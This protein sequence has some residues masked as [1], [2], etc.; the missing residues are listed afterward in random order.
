MVIFI[1]EKKKEMIESGEKGRAFDM[2]MELLSNVEYRV[3]KDVYK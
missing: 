3:N 1:G 2:E